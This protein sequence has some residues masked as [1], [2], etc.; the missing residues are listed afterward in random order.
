M[1]H[2]VAGKK[3]G[4]K[5][6]HRV[7]LFRNMVTA[8]FEHDRIVTTET[9]AKV[10]RPIADKLISQAKNN[11]LHNRRL[12]SVTVRNKTVL[13]RLFDEIAPRYANRQGGYTRV[14]KLGFRPGDAAMKAVLELVDAPEKVV[15]VK[16]EGKSSGKQAAADKPAETAESKQ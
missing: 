7:S 1:R 11:D 15:K 4:R 12:V 14:I 8:L 3:L 13:K 2:R 5:T 9:K 16:E 10:L 6:A